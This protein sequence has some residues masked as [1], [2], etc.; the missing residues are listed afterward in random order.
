MWFCLPVSRPVHGSDK[1]DAAASTHIQRLHSEQLW[2]PVRRLGSYSNSAT[3]L[4][5]FPIMSV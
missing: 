1:G 4:S 5:T 2:T 3:S